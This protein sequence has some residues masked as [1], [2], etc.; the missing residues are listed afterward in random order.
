MT[1]NHS[2]IR[3][4]KKMRQKLYAWFKRN[5]RSFIWRQKNDPFLIL[6]SEVFLKKTKA[7]TVER[8]LPF[9]LKEYPNFKLIASSSIRKLEHDLLPLGL[10]KQ[11]SRH[12]KKMA[13]YIYEN[14]AGKVPHDYYELI[15]IE[16]IGDYTASAVACFAFSQKRSIVDTNTTRIFSRISGIYCS[17]GE[18]RRNRKLLKFIN[19]FY[20][21]HIRKIKELNWA[22]LDLGALICKP[23]KPL[24][25]ECPVLSC[26]KFGKMHLIPIH[27]NKEGNLYANY[28]CNT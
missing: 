9:F 18:L 21:Q 7:G 27:H 12:L 4:S 5:R 23:R 11:R 19:N 28:K 2:I 14:Y 13:N 22:L 10:Y 26:C 24:C 16:G 20:A 1:G 25:R 3:N 15:R 8:Y 17:K 6:L